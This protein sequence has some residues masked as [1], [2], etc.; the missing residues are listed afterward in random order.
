MKFASWPHHADF[1]ETPLPVVAMC[2]RAGV[3]F[4][5]N[6]ILAEMLCALTMSQAKRVYAVRR[7]LVLKS[8]NEMR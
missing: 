5:L 4:F 2:Y 7:E 8:T 6:G 3:Q 1:V